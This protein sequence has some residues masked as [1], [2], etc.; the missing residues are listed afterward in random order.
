MVCDP[1][2]FHVT[3]ALLVP[4]PAVIVPPGALHEYPAMPV[5]VEYTCPPVFTQTVGGPSVIDGVGRGP[6]ATVITFEF[7][8]APPNEFS[9]RTL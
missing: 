8:D 7:K 3:V 1:E 5:C 9:A 2:L 4:W 6:V